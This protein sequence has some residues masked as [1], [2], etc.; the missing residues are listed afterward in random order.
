MLDN[1]NCVV[2]LANFRRIKEGSLTFHIGSNKFLISKGSLPGCCVLKL[3]LNLNVE[4]ILKAILKE[5]PLQTF[6]LEII[7]PD[8]KGLFN[9]YRYFI[10]TG[11]YKSVKPNSI[12]WKDSNGQVLE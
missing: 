10:K 8:C 3:E 1:H 5:H 9:S 4:V 11:K 7:K 2:D 12:Y 6:L